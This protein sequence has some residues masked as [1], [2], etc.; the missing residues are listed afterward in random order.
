[1]S[2]STVQ[3]FLTCLS[4]FG[5]AHTALRPAFG[6]AELG[7]GVTYFLP[8]PEQPV[9]VRHVDRE[10]LDGALR[11]VAPSDPRAARFTSL[12]RVI[13]SARM[14]IVD[15]RDG[16][17]A[18]DTVGRLQIAGDPVCLGYYENPDANREVFAAEGWFNTGDRGFISDGE[19][20]LTGRDKET[21]VI[22]GANYHN[23]EIESAV[24]AIPGIRV[25]YTAACAVRD[26]SHAERLALFFSTDVRD[27]D[28]L[29]ARI[30]E[31]QNGVS[32]K[33]GVKPDYLLPVD[34]EIIPKTAIG[35]IRRKELV[36]RFER[37]EFDALVQRVDL[38]LGNDRTIPDWFLRPAFRP[39]ALPIRSSATGRARRFLLVEDGYGLANRVAVEL[40]KRGV[41]SSIVPRTA[42]VPAFTGAF[43]DVVDMA[44]Y[45]PDHRALSDG[46]VMGRAIRRGIEL[47][48]HGI[49][50]PDPRSHGADTKL[51]YRVVASYS[52]ATAP[53]D[54]LDAARAMVPAVLA[55]L[56]QEMGTAECRHV[57]VPFAADENARAEVA[58]LV[59]AECV[60][61][62]R[63]EE[64]VYRNAQRL[65]RCF[66]KVSWSDPGAR[67]VRLEPGALYLVT[68]GLGG[69]GAELARYLL[70]QWGAALVIVGRTPLEG[71]ADG[72][73][74]RRTVLAELARRG[75]V[76]YE[77]ADTTDVAALS[78][79]VARA[80]TAA[81]KR[82]TGAFHL[83]SVYRE[84]PLARETAESLYAVFAPK[85]RGAEA[86]H[87]V[88]GRDAFLVCFSSLAGVFGGAGI[89]AYAAA[90]RC[91]DAICQDQR[92]RGRASYNLN[93]SLWKGLGIGGDGAPVEALSSKGYMPIAANKG[94]SSLAALLGLAPG[95]LMVGVDPDHPNVAWQVDAPAVPVGSLVGAVVLD[96][97]AGDVALDA[98]TARD[99]FDNTV[100]IVLRRTPHSC[101]TEAG[102]IDRAALLAD[103]RGATSET[104]VAPS[105][106]LEEQL[107]RIWQDVL[108]LDT[109]GVNESFFD[110]GGTSLLSVRLFAEIERAFGV[111]L[112][113]ATLFRASTIEALCALL[114]TE[115]SVEEA[116]S[117]RLLSPGNAALAIHL[118]H[119]AEGSP[120]LYQPL[121]DCLGSAARVY[122]IGPRC[123][124][125]F[126]SLHTRIGE[127][128]DH[129]VE[130]IRRA[131]P[132]G[133]YRV[134]GLGAG[135]V[136]AHEVA[137]RLQAAGEHVAMVALLDCMDVAQR[138]S[139]SSHK[140]GVFR[141]PEIGLAQRLRTSTTR[142]STALT[143]TSVEYARVR[144]L[145]HYLDRGEQPPWF[146]EHIPLE[147]IYRFAVSEFHPSRFEGRVTLFRAT[148][149][150]ASDD[151]DTPYFQL[152][153]DPF[154]GWGARASRG[155][156][157]IEV[158]G[159]HHSML[160]VPHVA[161]VA[162]ELLRAG[163]NAGAA[164]AAAG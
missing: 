33:T 108:G 70:E 97:G 150:K 61:D 58:R 125:S 40:E 60:A 127:M 101:L 57:D 120:A 64:V 15:E 7:S 2:S 130:K 148:G 76:Y 146:L 137:C 50:R 83:A 164:A 134:G 20:Y 159:G 129:H 59:V 100:P 32:R 43:T 27:D 25:S 104:R 12:G 29:R 19:L 91:L 109:V 49:A 94:F 84:L 65:A 140:S 23:G 6:M 44:D 158:A 56:A 99:V 119:D 72:D 88:L 113:L 157:L 73:G 161:S 90:N 105:T 143:R 51:C 106:P 116:R 141:R 163:G 155:V 132:H 46:D 103:L 68:G 24:E 11:R 85:V 18:E 41:A 35:K 111:G 13:P 142:L 28:E 62:A 96:A 126:P 136:L 118:I 98:S 21:L 160:L 42:D 135:G 128:V 122:G 151:S 9:R 45:G 77:A 79:A 117:L 71:L 52:Q 31:V 131:Q 54:P 4:P 147:T 89:G 114:S 63:D 110:L 156:E 153:R 39:K 86:L 48:R 16:V 139:G 107:A 102:R 8:T 10:S 133:P 80:E 154:L 144:L 67:S 121:A 14:R 149:S 53:A 69:V 1:V 36:K 145:R 81:G 92:A 152:C 112:P 82:V 17:V 93:W 55:A 123:E 34:A 74:A 87:A 66:D 22:N 95:Q 124:G 30:I 138:P 162:R 5:L 115:H 37:G 26:E 47:V 75:T 78:A 3:E 38:L